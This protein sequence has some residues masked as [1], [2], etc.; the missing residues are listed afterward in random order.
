MFGANTLKLSIKM[1]EFS[2][3]PFYI[4][5][6]LVEKVSLMNMFLIVLPGFVWIIF[7]VPFLMDHLRF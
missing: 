4:L 5:H 3:G 7:L 1:R 2:A 6:G